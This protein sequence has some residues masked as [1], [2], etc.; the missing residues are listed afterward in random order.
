MGRVALLILGV[1]LLASAPAAGQDSTG[2][3]LDTARAWH[4]D[5]WST[6]VTR[7]RLTVSYIFYG[8]ADTE[9]NGLVLRLENRNDH[10][11]RYAFTVIFRGPEGEATG[12]ADGQIGAQSMKTGESAGLFW[13][14]FRDGRTV[15]EVGLRGLTVTPVSED[16]AGNASRR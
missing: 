14:P 11:V 13:I 1:L 10:P 7:D 15:G 6:I 9:N 12:Q 2:V 3:P 5:A 4:E 16:G 8:K